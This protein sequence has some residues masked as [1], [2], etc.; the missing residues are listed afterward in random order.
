[1]KKAIPL[2]LILAAALPS[3]AVAAETAAGT[4]I[5]I[6]GVGS[7]V[8]LSSLLVSWKQMPT[9]ARD[10]IRRTFLFWKR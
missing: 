2:I 3:T 4:V 7:F 1:M 5:E 10:S 9:A 6:A 8:I